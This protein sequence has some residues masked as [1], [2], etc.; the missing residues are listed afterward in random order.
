VNKHI[1]EKRIPRREDS[2]MGERGYTIPVKEKKGD[3]IPG[4][5]RKGLD[6]R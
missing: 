4:R 3:R 2:R 1:K 5:G 6:S